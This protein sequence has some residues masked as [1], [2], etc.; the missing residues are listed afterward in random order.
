MNTEELNDYVFSKIVMELAW[1][2]RCARVHAL[3]DSGEITYEQGKEMPQ[4]RADVQ[5]ALTAVR[6]NKKVVF[7][8]LAELESAPTEPATPPPVEP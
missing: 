3:E 5:K 8:I 7:E 6:H 4:T 1:K 2:I